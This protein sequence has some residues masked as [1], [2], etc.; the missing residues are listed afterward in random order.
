MTRPLHRIRLTP[1]RAASAV[2]CALVLF[3]PGAHGLARRSAWPGGVATVGYDSP[4]SLRAVLARF[5][6]VVVRRVPQLRVAEV[7]PRGPL[8]AFA[9]AVSRLPGIRYVERLAPRESASE[10]ALAPSLYP[11]GTYEWQYFAARE[12]EVPAA[13]LRAASRFTIAI[14]DTGADVT[15]PDLAA[16]SP[17]THSIASDSAD[18][19]D[20]TG[21]G[22]FV[23]ALAAGSVTNG[24][25]IAGFGG[26]AQLMVV[27]AGPSTGSFSDVDEAAAIVWAV[28][29]GAEIV[30]L[31]LGG[32]DTS[33]TEQNAVDY[34]VARGALLVAAAG[35]EYGS[36]D[37]VEYPAAL[38]QPVGSNG[39][40][41][42]GLSVAAS[43]IAG[44]R[45]SFSNTGSY[46]SLA[47]PGEN[48]FSALSSQAAEG[49]FFPVALPGSQ[50]GLYGFGSGTSFAAPEVAGAA[51][52]VWAANPF[53]TARQVAE[54]MK[55][56]AGGNGNW[57]S[58]LGY[59]VINV[60]AAVQKASGGAVKPPSV[61]IGGRRVGGTVQLSWVGQ[62]A[63]AYRLRVKRDG[64]KAEV[65]IDSTMRTSA[66]LDV[67]PGHRYTFV[68][69]AL[70]ATGV[71]AAKSAPFVVDV[72]RSAS[73]V[74]LT[75]TPM[76]GRHPL[77]VR[78]TAVLNAKEGGVAPG[79][80]SV[81]LEV[82]LNG[83][84]RQAS[85]SLTSASGRATWTFKLAPGLYR[86]RALFPA[87]DD[88]A[89]ST[90]RAVVIRVS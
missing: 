55:Q 64:G 82:V 86:L 49:L 78:L 41:G 11:G 84:W 35:N 74:M 23:A 12:N 80:R 79:S 39:V 58:G 1:V 73:S 28:D 3:V 54:T 8:P 47:A 53:L 19:R 16:K 25:G 87:T 36:G 4:G 7:R 51:A 76:G 85:S 60:A 45:A 69:S 40:G 77:S 14:V 13:V 50:A 10:P 90:S 18:V 30:N 33:L 6:G 59:G 22:T 52:L 89:A 38:L 61:S 88:L 24:E 37:P 2:G 67:V 62:R 42:A 43:Q 68:V 81:I 44:D 20:S 66:A 70:D 5:P 65:L 75:A 83:S 29:H 27:Q 71:E 32:S 56:T 63:A 34:A 48:V 9:A 72:P 17:V 21:H 31:S 57:D 46:I 26:D 15:A